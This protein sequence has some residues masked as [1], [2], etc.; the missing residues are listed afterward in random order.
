[1]DHT[2]F[3]ESNGSR[4][5]PLT[6]LIGRTTELLSV[7]TLLLRDETRLLT[8]TGPGG[9]GKT[10][11]SRHATR[12]TEDSFPDGVWFVSLATVMDPALVVP[13]AMRAMGISNDGKLVP[14]ERLAQAV[15]DKRLLLVLDNFE[16][17]ASEA[18]SL[19]EILR[20]CPRITMLVTS[21]ARLRVSGEHEFPVPPME[22]AAEN[23]RDPE[24]I[25]NVET[26]RLFISRAC[27]VQPDF[28]VTGA[29]AATIAE[30]C[31]RV[32]GL[33]L[34][35][36]LAAARL[37]LLGLDELR[38]RLEQSLPLL[39]GG[40]RDLPERQQTMRN[41]IA[42]SY[43]LLSLGEQ[44]LLRRLSVL[45]GSF[46]FEAAQAIG[47]RDVTDDLASLIDHSLVVRLTDDAPV[48]RY[49]T[50][51]VIRDYG[52][53]Q[54][55]IRGEHDA[56]RLRHANH[57]RDI[58][59]RLRPSIEG[60]EASEVL[61]C[62][63]LDHPNYLAALVTATKLGDASLAVRLA[64]ALWKPWYVHGR[65]R[66]AR[67]WLGA[68]LALP[69]EMPP[70]TKAEVLYAA[71]GF[72]LD[73]RDF[74]AGEEHARECLELSVA[75]HDPLHTGMALYVLG[76][77]ARIQGR[78]GESLMTWE[79]ALSAVQRARPFAGF[80]EH[81]SGM[82][83]SSLGAMA[84]EQGQIIRSRELNEEALELWSRRADPWG[85]ANALHNLAV[86]TSETDPTAATAR[87]RE[88]LSRY[89]D[90]GDPTG[91]SNSL[92]GLAIVAI[93]LGRVAEGAGLLGAAADIR[94][95]RNLPEPGMMKVEYSSAVAAARKALGPASFD[96]AW[97]AGASRPIEKT[98]AEAMDL[99][100]DRPLRG[101]PASPFG[102]SS[103]ELEV[104]RLVAEG[105][106]D[107]VIADTL[108][109]SYRT[110]TT[111]VTRILIKLGVDSRTA[112]ASTAVREG[113]V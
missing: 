41:T 93:R 66:E 46:D 113:I 35:I 31:R 102:L 20:A 26:V 11:L 50:L 99:P 83:L 13:T 61:A 19:V 74:G 6:P 62:F 33:P 59:E 42:W 24:A 15:G 91:L 45:A 32:D 86:A 28:S 16:Q 71:A 88:A 109:I 38:A 79:Q 70:G 52:I 58:A 17:V 67:R 85:I 47:G 8:L 87:F 111:H 29:R 57:F 80:A 39:S 44:E 81:M 55:D 21:R 34:A 72:A 43:E 5:R 95:T 96:M 51:Q 76:S 36:E 1:M 3:L 56:I 77:L 75:A 84:Y 97:E 101:K 89:R 73:Q 12:A 60:P 65:A 49:T 69:G 106:T 40:N 25:A 7:I 112:A 53:E 64:A 92:A 14:R 82:I 108:S 18:P 104:L 68:V 48:S 107:Q 94:S 98:L 27:A 2:S 37:K 103:R 10:T 30:I 110:A 54:L 90:L 9:V 78:F 23:S 105:R 22:L 63:E 4:S 100:L